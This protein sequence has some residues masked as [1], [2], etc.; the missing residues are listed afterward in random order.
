MLTAPNPIIVLHGSSK[1]TVIITGIIVK[2]PVVSAKVSLPI[3]IYI[4]IY[5]YICENSPIYAA[6]CSQRLKSDEKPVERVGVRGWGEGV[7]IR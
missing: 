1:V 2:K 7:D 5:I 6:V 3:Y 4:Y